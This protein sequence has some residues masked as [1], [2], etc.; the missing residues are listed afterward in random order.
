MPVALTVGRTA[1]CQAVAV[2][3][4][5][6]AEELVRTQF[7]TIQTP[8][9]R[10]TLFALSCL[11]AAI[12]AGAVL[13]SALAAGVALSKRGVPP[14]DRWPC[15]LL[16]FALGSLLVPLGRNAE[17]AQLAAWYAALAIGPLVV[18]CLSRQ[19]RAVQPVG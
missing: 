12:S 1:L 13:I 3:G 19:R 4:G 5:V 14:P 16:S 11:M 8:H 17:G 2:A 7:W 10:Q 15:A 9:A 18:Q 6:G